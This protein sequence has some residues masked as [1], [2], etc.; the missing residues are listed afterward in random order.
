MGYIDLHVHSKY[1][2]GKMD[3]DKLLEKAKENNVTT[4]S[5]TEHYNLSSLRQAKK[6]VHESNIFNE[7]EI[8]PGIEIGANMQDMGYSK[9]HVCHILAYFVS[10]KI[11]EILSKYEEDR[12]KTNERII[13]RLKNEGIDITYGKVMKMVKNKS[14]GRYDIAKYLSKNGYAYTP[15]DAFAKFLDYGQMAH[16]ERKKMSPEKLIEEIVKCGGVPVIAHPRS[17]K[18][19]H[20]NFEDLISKLVKVGLAGIE[21]Y[22]PRNK[23]E[24]REFY[25][26]MCDKFN[27]ISTVGS[28]FHKIGGDVEIGLGINNNLCIDD[29]SIITNLKLKKHEIELVKKAKK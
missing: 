28:D 20:E 3:I 8:I 6:L 9:N 22:N 10:T 12:K 21:V 29:Y 18:L 24:E 25:L 27:L 23:H 16:I 17:L 5:F 11:Y 1:S 7:I 26:S 14:F 15:E 13:E 4:I 19:N 2:D